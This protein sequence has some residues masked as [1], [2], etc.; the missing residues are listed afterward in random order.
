MCCQPWLSRVLLEATPLCCEQMP[1]MTVPLW[2]SQKRRHKD[3][4][5]LTQTHTAKVWGGWALSS[6]SKC[7][8][9]ALAWCRFCLHWIRYLKCP[10]LSQVL[11]P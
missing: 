4:R 8:P 1:F 3:T 11:R 5:G 2:L 6:K 9:E 7:L 10:Q